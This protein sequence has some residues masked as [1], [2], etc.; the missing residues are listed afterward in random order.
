MSRAPEPPRTPLTWSPPAPPASSPPATP[1]PTS[2]VAAASPSPSPP[3]PI[4]LPARFSGSWRQ[5]WRLR[6][7]LVGSGVATLMVDG[8]WLQ[9]R[10]TTP[11]RAV[12]HIGV[13]LAFWA[14]L[15]AS[16]AFVLLT[17]LGLT[18][19]TEKPAWLL[20]VPLVGMPLTWLVIWIPAA[21]LRRWLQP[22]VKV[23]VPWSAVERLASEGSFL[24][25]VA[26]LP[27]GVVW[28]RMRP[29]WWGR[30]TAEALLRRLRD[31]GLPIEISTVTTRRP[32]SVWVDRLAVL[33]VLGLLSWSA[34]ELRGRF[35]SEGAETTVAVDTPALE[36]T[37]LGL[38]AAE[39]GRAR[40]EIPA[41]ASGGAAV[42]AVSVGARAAWK[43][44]RDDAQTRDQRA[45]V[46]EGLLS[47]ISWERMLGAL[48]M[49][50]SLPRLEMLRQR[51]DGAD[52]S[53]TL[54]QRAL[55][56][57]AG[58]YLQRLPDDPGIWLGRVKVAR[59]WLAVSAG[60]TWTLDDHPVRVPDG[61]TAEIYK[62]IGRFLLADLAQDV[63]DAVDRGHA[64]WLETLAVGVELERHGVHLN[65]QPSS[66]SKALI[67]WG[68]GDFEYVLDRA[69]L[70]AQQAIRDEEAAVA[71]ARK[72]GYRLGS[73]WSARDG[74]VRYAEVERNGRTLGWLALFD[75]SKMVV[76][77][78][79]ASGGA[80]PG[81]GTLLL[82]SGAYVTGDGRSAGLAVERGRVENYLLDRSM[83]GMV[84][85]GE[86]VQVLNLRDGATMGGSRRLLRPL[87]LLS[88]L[89]ALIDWIKRQGA[90]AFQTH[91]L[92]ANGKLTISGDRASPE[93]RE[94]RLLITA[95]YGRAPILAVLDIPG[96]SRMSLYEAAIVGLVTLETPEA[97]GGPGLK[98]DGIANLDVGSYDIL[99]AWSDQGQRLRSGQ[100][101]MEQAKNLMRITRRR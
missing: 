32:R 47:V 58:A 40:M 15:L 46:D 13:R 73:G 10:R 86:G 50:T 83:G 23:R 48:S 17:A 90:S 2:Q 39:L 95:R 4:A 78:G 31:G 97:Q 24:E 44:L 57:L 80:S 42:D 93:L 87:D 100:V 5:D 35:W 88:D 99:G 41:G 69:W 29:R 6:G 25:L 16:W 45:E 8:L 60:T 82:T 61:P 43:E 70:K 92:V 18:L 72:A 36:L 27:H 65:L 96:G 56:G 11:S 64:P 52:P 101:P 62:A 34:T 77:W 68:T 59:A 21:I 9:G 85:F 28:G 76:D 89:Y 94:R 33:G 49:R 1:P 38:R 30:A 74:A 3:K 81:P 98:V 53:G 7:E 51:L 84:V 55:F 22:K 12:L 63:E 26:R 91:V 37:P 67:A 79:F 19:R 20:V 75:A 14:A 66:S 54:G 71:A